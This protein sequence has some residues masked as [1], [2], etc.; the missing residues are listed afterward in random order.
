MAV[1]EIRKY[2]DAVLKR[3]ARAVEVFDNELQ[4]LIDDMVETMHAAPGIGLAAPQV[5]VSKQLAVID[6][7]TDEQKAPLI[8]LV[9]P[10]IVCKEGSIDFEEGCLSVPEYTAMVSRSERIVVKALDREGRPLEI[11]TTDLLAI[12]LQ[13]EID[14][15]EGIL[16]VDRMSAFKR[17]LFKKRYKTAV[18]A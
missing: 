11:E 2:P 3:R 12:V 1:M 7:S 6:M 8:V 14:H 15:L 9:N 16:M 10:V 17:E 13:H 5:G 4:A 18:K